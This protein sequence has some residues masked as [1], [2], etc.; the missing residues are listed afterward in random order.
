[1]TMRNKK[2]KQSKK[3]AVQRKRKMNLRKDRAKEGMRGKH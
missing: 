3:R 1:M 2:E